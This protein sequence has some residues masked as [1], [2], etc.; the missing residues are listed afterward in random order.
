MPTD[1]FVSDRSLNKLMISRHAIQQL[2]DPY[3]CSQTE[4]DGMTRI[5][6]TVLIQ[7]GIEHQPMVG[8]LRRKQKKL[9]PHFWID[10]PS[11]DRID[12][13][14]SMWLGSDSV[15]HGVFNPEDF[16]DVIY[17]GRKIELEPLP[18]PIFQLLIFPYTTKAN[19]Y[20][21]STSEA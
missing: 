10:L 18:D 11:G 9:Y 15:P 21:C 3:D 7:H 12:Y 13:R 16:S 20:G 1:R 19:A 14:A 17:K 2:L 4:C 5:C 6:H 8:T